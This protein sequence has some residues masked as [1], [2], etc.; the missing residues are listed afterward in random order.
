MAILD[1]V[2]KAIGFETKD[3][4]SYFKTQ[5]SKVTKFT[6]EKESN[7][8]NF[9][10]KN[11]HSKKIEGQNLSNVVVHSPKLQTDVCRVVAC[12]QNNQPA[13]VDLKH[14]GKKDLPR[15]LDY[16]S[17]AVFALKGEINRLEGDL[18]LLTPRSVE[19]KT[20]LN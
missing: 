9:L 15:V 2:A 6:N 19:V 13:I 5:N 14:I 4:N 16:I 3:E 17:G 12:L 8:S 11:K 7:Y 20:E 10:S 18:F 1:W